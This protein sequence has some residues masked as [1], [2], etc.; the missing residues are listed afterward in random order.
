[1]FS[2]VSWNMVVDMNNGPIQRASLPVVCVYRQLKILQTCHKAHSQHPER[3]ECRRWAGLSISAV[4]ED[5]QQYLQ[6][7]RR[8]RAGKAGIGRTVWG[9]D[10]AHKGG[11]VVADSA[12]VSQRPS[13]PRQ[14][15]TN[16]L[17][18]SPAN[19]QRDPLPLTTFS[20]REGI[21]P[22]FPQGVLWQYLSRA[23]IQYSLFL[24][25]WSPECCRAQD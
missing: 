15:D 20:P 16:L 9:E 3:K 10:W 24:L 17:G 22:H 21:N 12:A 7:V 2:T 18:F 25:C 1:M 13:R 23:R 6:T 19:M 14:S 11:G 8:F 4:R 5:V